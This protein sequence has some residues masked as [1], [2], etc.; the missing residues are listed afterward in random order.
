MMVILQNNNSAEVRSLSSSTALLDDVKV[1]RCN[2][3]DLHG[4]QSELLSG[5]MPVGSVE[6]VQRSLQLAGVQQPAFNPYDSCLEKYWRRSISIESVRNVRADFVDKSLFVKPV[7]LKKF[8]GFIYKGDLSQAYD[9][10]D[11]EQL[12]ILMTLPTHEKIYTA[13]VVDFV[14]EWRCYILNG[15]LLG[16]CRHDAGDNDYEPDNDLVQ[17]IVARLPGRTLAADVGLTA[18]GQF[19]VVELNDAWAIGK[20]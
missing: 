12:K 5:A 16:V 19:C 18:Q 3:D 10:H 2:Y 6:F 14:A 8:N 4:Y 20:Y 17:Q 11:V 7:K 1:I 13:D 15:Q 9:V